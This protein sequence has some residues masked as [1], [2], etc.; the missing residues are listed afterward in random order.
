M[1]RIKILDGFRC[2]A[3]LMVMFDH[4][5]STFT[6]VHTKG[7]YPYIARSLYPFGDK[8][9][10][11]FEN[12][13]LGVELFYLISGFVIY[14]TLEKTAT[15]KNF[16]L[17]RI[18]RLF[19]L[20]L[21]CSIVTYL[22]PYLLDPGNKYLLFHRPAANFL[23]S[24]TFT[25]I[26]M[27]NKLFHLNRT[28]GIEYIDNSYWTLGVEMK[29]YI[30]IGIIYFMSKKDFFLKWL[31]FTLGIICMYVLVSILDKNDSLRY[32]KSLL[33]TTF[34]AKYIIYFSVGAL[35]YRL[36]EQL[37]IRKIEYFVISV[38]AVICMV[39][40]MPWV[41]IIAFFIFIGFFLTFIYAPSRISLLSAKPIL[42][43]GLISYPLYLIHQNIGVLLLNIW[44][45]ATK[46]KYSEVFILPVM[47][48][49]IFVAYLLHKFV[50]VPLGKFS[51]KLFKKKKPEQQIATVYNVEET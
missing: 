3:I 17:K 1:K 44:T 14:L 4:Y 35:F 42:F 28:N 39:S 30:Y 11:Y 9:H 25:D 13:Y 33:E 41:E 34:F 5:T 20:L 16:I 46:I 7:M 27:W 48:L 45:D 51:K 23:P 19:P 36:Y 24:V 37:P 2:L 40:F 18:F 50:E 22:V 10:I 31:Y 6:K 21:L 47:G 12:G 29:F 15:F 43:I 32:Y 26:W 8:Y 38:A 49:M